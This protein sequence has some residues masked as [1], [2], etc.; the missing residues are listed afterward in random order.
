MYGRSLRFVTKDNVSM[1]ALFLMLS[2]P[3]EGG[4]NLEIILNVVELVEV[5]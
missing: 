3:M 2:Q 1:V 4:M 5:D